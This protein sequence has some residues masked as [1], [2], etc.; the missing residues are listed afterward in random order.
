MYQRANQK[1]YNMKFTELMLITEGTFAKITSISQ[2][3][4]IIN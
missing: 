4:K 1:I 2:C 3:F